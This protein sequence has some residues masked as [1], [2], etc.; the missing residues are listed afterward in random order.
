MVSAFQ[1][2]HHIKITRQEVKNLSGLLLCEL[3][4]FDF[5]WYIVCELSELDFFRDIRFEVG[6]SDAFLLHGVAVTNGHTVVF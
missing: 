1:S 6:D 2:N 5:P 4:E 3:S